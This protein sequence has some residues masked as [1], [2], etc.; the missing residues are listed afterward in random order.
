MTV[1]TWPSELPR[2]TRQNWRGQH[3]DPRLKKAA[4]A[5]PPGYRRRYSSV[6]RQVGLSIIVTRTGKAIFDT[7]HRQTTN[8]GALPFW[9]P[10]PTTDG[11]P[12]LTGAGEPVLTAA[13]EP[14]LMSAQ[15]LCLFGDAMPVETVK[16][17]EF[18]IAF[19]VS[20]MP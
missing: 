1:A 15:W 9:M 20:V 16:R 19:S 12:M 17:V 2:P 3:D 6:A 13:G 10:D 14:V 4:S 7:F 11:W 18:Q 8:Y 5:G